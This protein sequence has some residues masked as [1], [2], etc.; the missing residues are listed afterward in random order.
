MDPGHSRV[1]LRHLS[2]LRNCEFVNSSYLELKLNLK[3]NFKMVENGICRA[4]NSGQIWRKHLELIYFLP[5]WCWLIL[6]YVLHKSDQMLHLQNVTWN[7][8]LVTWC[9][10]QTERSV[11]KTR[12]GTHTRSKNWEMSI[13]FKIYSNYNQLYLSKILVSFYSLNE[14]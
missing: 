7:Y 14:K 2:L 10:G 6:I 4:N 13:L 8:I 11:H 5:N 9:F 12:I 1:H 3:L